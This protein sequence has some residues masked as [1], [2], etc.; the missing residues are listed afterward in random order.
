M[1]Y[2]IGVGSAGIDG[3]VEIRESP[4]KPLRMIHNIHLPTGA[5]HSF[6]RFRGGTCRG[7]VT[8]IHLH[9]AIRKVVTPNK[10][11]RLTKDEAEVVLK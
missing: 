3:W 6:T 11:I 10:I 8:N 7:V 1:F 9:K 5:Q 2:A 4:T